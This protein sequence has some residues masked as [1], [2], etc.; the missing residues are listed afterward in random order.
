LVA[1]L[2]EARLD[3]WAIA[4]DRS[5][6]SS[7]AEVG[8]AVALVVGFAAVDAAAGAGLFGAVVLVA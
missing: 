3:L 8:F 5:F 7:R 2:S 4:F 1:G 6:A